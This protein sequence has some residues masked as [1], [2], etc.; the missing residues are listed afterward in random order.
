LDDT[1]PDPSR[2]PCQGGLCFCTIMTRRALL[3]RVVSIQEHV[4]GPQHP[5]ENT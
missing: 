1:K 4:L 5:E 2:L 3:E